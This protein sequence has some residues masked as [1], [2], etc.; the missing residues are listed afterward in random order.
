M[1]DPNSE[2]I[3]SQLTQ[4]WTSYYKQSDET[5]LAK[6]WPSENLVRMLNGSYI[7]NL[8][9]DMYGKKAL[10]VGC[11]NGANLIF[12]SSLGLE[13][14]GTEINDEILKETDKLLKVSGINATLRT[15]KNT[16]LPFKNDYFDILVSFNVIH[17]ETSDEGI[18]KAIQEYSRVLKPGGRF[19][20]STTGPNDKILFSAKKLRNRI[21]VL[22]ID[23]DVRNGLTYYCFESSDYLKDQLSGAFTQVEVGRSTEILF[24]DTLDW[25]LATGIKPII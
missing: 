10:D 15:G 20:I 1:Q 25:F 23:Q 6:T 7:K 5:G 17:Y 14:Y 3:N 18:K 24:E 4:T 9:H 12:L 21:Y 11:G 19:I 2:P 13:T 16:S 8:D 22:K